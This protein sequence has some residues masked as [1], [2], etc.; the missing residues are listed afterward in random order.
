MHSL[1]KR[2]LLQR[3]LFGSG[4]LGL[5]ALA[6]GLPASFL[7][8]QRTALA[9]STIDPTFL[10][11]SNSQLG[12]PIN[13]NCPGTYPQNPGDTNDP[14]RQIDHPQV[15]Q[16]GNTV[17]GTVNGTNFRAADFQ[18]PVD[19]RLGGN[20]YKA[21][22][23]W[24]ALPAALRN[25]M[26]FFHHSTYAN[27]HPEFSNVMRFH[28]AVKGQDGTGQEMLSSAIAQETADALGTLTTQPI[29]LGGS[30]VTY[31]GATLGLFRP[32]QIKSL[33]DGGQHPTRA[34]DPQMVVRLRD[35]T[36]DQIYRR[37]QTSGSA[38]QKAFLDRYALGRAQAAQ[39]GDQL[40]PLLQNVDADG[41]VAQI[42]TAVALFRLRVTPVVVL[43]APFGG[44]NHQD[45][46]LANE[47]AQTIQS[48]ETIRLLWTELVA[49]GLQDQVTFA[50]LDTFGRDLV[51]N[52]SG[53]RDHNRDH[54]TMLMFGPRIVPSV[55]GRLEPITNRNGTLRDFG[56]ASIN[57]IPKEQSLETAGKTLAKAV[58]LS[59]ARINTRILGG[60]ILTRLIN[61]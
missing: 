27:A 44:D 57:N 60:R 8:N 54:H 34:T 45:T 23:P 36:L 19:L 25:R 55:V 15:S 61:S 17:R 2:E 22:G 18:N 32:R 38:A 5:R 1:S 53:G 35:A 43:Q 52:S 26:A 42:R 37:V 51:R 24:A 20:T 33:F 14:L 3:A 4:A 11:L 40:G 46:Q 31:E 12:H 16:L 7:L 58:G 39:L 21:A 49:A 29:N 13:A 50:Y 9:Q 28:G 59:D 48:V 6:T 41:P 47:V 30:R 56:V 10:V